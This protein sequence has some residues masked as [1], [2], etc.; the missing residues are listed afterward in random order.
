MSRSLVTKTLPVWV[1]I[2]N[3]NGIN[4]TLRPATVL[5]RFTADRLESLLRF[6]IRSVN[7]LPKLAA[8]ST[9]S[10]QPPHRCTAGGGG[11]SVP[12]SAGALPD[13]GAQWHLEDSPELQALATV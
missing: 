5:W 11:G 3:Y 2:A 10:A 1:L 6:H 7:S 9:S 12:E 4:R 13:A 8:N